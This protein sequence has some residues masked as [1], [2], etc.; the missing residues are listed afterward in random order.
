MLGEAAGG[1]LRFAGALVLAAAPRR[2]WRALE[3]RWP[4]PQARLASALLTAGLAFGLGIPGFLRYAARVADVANRITFEAATREVGGQLAAGTVTSAAPV[5]IGLLSLPAFLFFT[6]LG[7]LVVVLFASGLTRGIAVAAGEP[8]GDPLA[9]ALHALWT[10]WRERRLRRAMAA[11]R[12]AREGP[13]VPDVCLRGPRAGEPEAAFVIVSSRRKAGWEEGVFVVTA[14]AWYRLGRP[15][16]R[17]PAG[18]LRTFY[19]LLPVAA[20]EAIRRGVRYELP[21]PQDAP[22][23]GGER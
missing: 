21:P 12:E 8:V 11:E 13:E 3:E 4:L 7:W 19:P 9:S 2:T 1:A 10:S 14:D 20:A 17:R 23:S 22:G 15:Y 16:D 5:T 18:W 6:P